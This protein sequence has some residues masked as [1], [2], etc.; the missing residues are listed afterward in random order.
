RVVDAGD[1]HGPGRLAGDVIDLVGDAA[2]CQVD[3]GAVTTG[4]G[5]GGGDRRHGVVP[6]DGCEAALAGAPPHRV[7]EATESA[8]LGAALCRERLDIGQLCRVERVGRVQREQ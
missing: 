3:R 4:S 1:T 8:Q 6:H 5:D 2:A 7:T